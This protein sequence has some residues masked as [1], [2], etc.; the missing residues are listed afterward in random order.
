M[1]GFNV[2]VSDEPMLVRGPETPIMK[3]GVWAVSGPDC[4][5]DI[6][7]PV[8]AWPD[9]ASPAI[10]REDA[11]FLT[12]NKD[13][14]KWRVNDVVLGSDDPIVVQVALPKE[15]TAKVGAPHYLFLAFRSTAHDAAGQITGIE[16]WPLVCGPVDKDAEAAD[17]AD[18]MIT[19]A[20][21]EGLTMVESNCHADSVASLTHAAEKSEEIAEKKG[22]VRWIKDVGPVE[23]E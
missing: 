2:V 10:I 3:P 17:G 7:T 16:T 8:D 5:Y 4:E 20:P 21:F 18:A 1:A 11:A 22:A 14:G 9:C 12:L 13:S 15:V 23:T 6:A 19:K